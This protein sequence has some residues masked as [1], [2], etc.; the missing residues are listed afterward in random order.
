LIL[1]PQKLLAPFDA[2]FDWKSLLESL[3]QDNVED[4]IR[5]KRKKE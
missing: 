3:R 1:D 4:F 5:E 2:G